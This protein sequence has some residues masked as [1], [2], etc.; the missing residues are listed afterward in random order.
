MREVRSKKE[1]SL[2]ESIFGDISWIFLKSEKKQILYCCDGNFRYTTPD[3]D[4][5]GNR[6]VSFEKKLAWIWREVATTG[7]N[8][9]RTIRI[10]LQLTKPGFLC[11][12]LF[13][14]SKI[15]NWRFHRRNQN[16]DFG[17]EWVWK[18]KRSNSFPI[19][20]TRIA[21]QGKNWFPVW[22]A[23]LLSKTWQFSLWIFNWKWML[24]RTILLNVRKFLNHITSLAIQAYEESLAKN[25][26]DHFPLTI[27]K[28]KNRQ[29]RPF[30]E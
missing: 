11:W 20:C 13:L 7:K 8:S 3:C 26:P 2:N 14:Q 19:R 25:E 15:F 27:L 12:L 17:R 21:F 22:N 30:W 9:T 1:K 24:W 6:A 4:F 29:F 23:L 5:G 10:K 16:V 18:Q 28:V